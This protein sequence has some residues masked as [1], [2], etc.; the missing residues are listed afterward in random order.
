M[1]AATI[2]P[3]ATAS[4]P[5]LTGR[6]PGSPCGSATQGSTR[7]PRARAGARCSWRS[8]TCSS[9]LSRASV[10]VVRR[11]LQCRFESR[12]LRPDAPAP[13][14]SA[15]LRRA[16]ADRRRLARLAGSRA[17]RAGRPLGRRP[18]AAE[19]RAGGTTLVRSRVR[20]ERVGSGR[21]PELSLICRTPLASRGRSWEAR[22]MRPYVTESRPDG[23]RPT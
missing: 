2:A 11:G 21:Y 20:A 8:R 18:A 16:S 13:T 7:G 5:R 23:Q 9:A 12:S 4:R 10:R 22:P 15:S 1:A 14:T 6:H 19:P 17:G 3:V